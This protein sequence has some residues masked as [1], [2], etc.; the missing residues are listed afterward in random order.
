MTVLWADPVVHGTVRTEALPRQDRC[1]GA[2]AGVQADAL[3]AQRC[4]APHSCGDQRGVCAAAAA[5]GDG[6]AA[7]EEAKREA[8]EGGHSARREGGSGG[9]IVDHEAVYARL[10]AGAV[11]QVAPQDVLSRQRIVHVKGHPTHPAGV[12]QALESI[13]R[14]DHQP[15]W[16][17][18]TWGVGG[19]G[20]GTVLVDQRVAG[21]L[22]HLR[23]GGSDVGGVE[24]HPGRAPSVV[25]SDLVEEA[26]QRMILGAEAVY[27]V[28]LLCALGLAEQQQLRAIDHGDTRG[29]PEQIPLRTLQKGIDVHGAS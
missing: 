24:L 12:A 8:G 28:E 9:A 20:V 26:G 6:A 25:V 17:R 14:V 2:R 11:G 3:N 7:P 10:G 29:D 1:R 27:G 5:G 4:G 13:D 18:G 15:A 21:L 23:Q 22:E 16:E 19:Q